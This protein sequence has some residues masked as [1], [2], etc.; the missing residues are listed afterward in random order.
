MKVVKDFCI[1]CGKPLSRGHKTEYCQQHLIEHRREEKIKTW[2]ETGSVGMTVDTTIR[3]VIREYIF[4]EQD[5]KC[6]ICGISNQW[7]GQTLNFVLD[8]IDG[9]A[10]NSCRENL[11]LICPNCD[12]QLDTF[13]SRNKNSSRTARKE[14]LKE[15]TNTE[16]M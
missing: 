13:K 3:G 8:H 15:H 10:S 9:D 11:R 2:L 12:S 1:V 14:F 7:N 5:K 6:A 16:Q 4:N